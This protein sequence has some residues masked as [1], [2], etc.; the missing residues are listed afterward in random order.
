MM[1]ETD[2]PTCKFPSIQTRDRLNEVCQFIVPRQSNT[3]IV[4]N[5]GQVPVLKGDLSW[6]SPEVY[7]FLNECVQLMTPS[8]IRICNGSVFEAQE[9][10]DAIANEFGSEELKTLDRLHMKISDVGFDDVHVVTKDR[11]DA[12]PGNPVNPSPGAL[13][14][15]SSGEN[16]ENVRLSSH[17]MTTKLFDFS[18][19]KRFNGCMN[20]RTMYLVPFSMGW[21]GSRHAVV[22]V[23]ITDDPVLVLNLRTTF[24]V[25]S[26]VWDCIAATTNFLRSVHSIGMPRPIIRRIVTPP[27]TE[28]PIGSFIVLKHDDQQIW[29][30]GY[31]FGRTPRFGKTFSIHAASWLGTKKGWLAENAS[32]L[33]ITNS[34]NETINVC[35]SGLMSVT[36]LQ[37]PAGQSAGWKVEV[38]SEKTVWIHWHN[39]KMYAL[40]PENDEMDDM[41]SPKNLSNL[42][43]GATSDYQIQSF[44]PQK[45]KWSTDVGVPISAY[46][47]ANRR[48][49]QYPLILEANSWEEGVCLA[50]GMRVSVPKTKTDSSENTTDSNKRYNLIECP[51]LRA[52]P[53]NF[54]F[55]KYVNHWLE[56]GIGVKS[57]SDSSDTYEAPL[58]PPIFFTNLYQE[59]DGK[60]IW[61]GGVDNMKIFEYIYGRCTN[62]MET[63]N[64][65][66]SG[67][68]KVPK[69]LE[70]SALVNLPPLLQVDIRFWLTELMKFRTFFNIQM[71]CC[72]PPQLDKV[73]TDLAGNI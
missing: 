43:T 55:A 39:G 32:I 7:I 1:K 70:L 49:D 3:M 64:T 33:A 30:H 25:L 59:T 47:F 37:L 61:P 16:S 11:M 42:L 34:K 54:S 44:N 15:S 71:E 36:S 31:T 6:L 35:Y 66:P 41:G 65:T 20:G 45:T 50:A 46:I 28:T 13:S 22:G 21:I 29:S 23:Q 26:S 57:P 14:N 69:S 40:C 48:H 62:P 18:K 58:P 8:A 53:I 19:E 72:L 38:L 52:D 51:M 68:G 56:M 5:Y 9:L 4:P 63:S 2:C 67:I 60:V 73:L 24:R 17:Y 27:P 10:R 12:D